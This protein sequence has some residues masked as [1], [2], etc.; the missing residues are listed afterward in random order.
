MGLAEGEYGL[1]VT[2]QANNMS[3]ALPSSGGAR[4]LVL[5]TTV[6]IGGGLTDRIELRLG[7]NPEVCCFKPAMMSSSDQWRAG[8]R[9]T[10]HALQ[11]VQQC[12]AACMAL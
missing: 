10:L 11:I 2:A 5:V 7:D 9:A 8:P 12:T 6:E 1:L 4:P 3:S